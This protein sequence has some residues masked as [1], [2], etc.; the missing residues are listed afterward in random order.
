MARITTKKTSATLTTQKQL[1]FVSGHLNEPVDGATSWTFAEYANTGEEACRRAV[2]T[3]AR[4]GLKFTMEL[5][6]Y[7]RGPRV[8][9]GIASYD[10][11]L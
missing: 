7:A 1:F 4:Y 3:A 9:R 11:V 5:C 2:T 8:K 10:R 6:V